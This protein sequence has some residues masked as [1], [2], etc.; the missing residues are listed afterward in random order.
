MKQLVLCH[1]L[2]GW[3]VAP[4]AGAWIETSVPLYRPPSTSV[5]PHAGAWIE[6]LWSLA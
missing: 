5:A 2:A 4:H 1:R 6:T 3:P